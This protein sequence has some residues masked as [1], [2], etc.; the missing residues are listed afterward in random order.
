MVEHH[1]WLEACREPKNGMGVVV[2]LILPE[3]VSSKSNLDF[4]MLMASND[5]K[6]INTWASIPK[7]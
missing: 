3:H 6:I 2:H 7:L 5:P 1:L 4:R